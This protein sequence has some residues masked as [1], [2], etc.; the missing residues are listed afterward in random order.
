VRS[1]RARLIISHLVPL[2]ILAV[3]VGVALTYLLQTQVLLAERSNELE[4]QAYLVAEA[5]SLN[6]LIWYDS[7]QA[8]AFTDR[9]GTLLSARLMLLSP[10]GKLLATNYDTFSS[11]IGQILEVPGLTET[12]ESGSALRVNYKQ[13]SSS[14]GAEVLVPVI[15]PSWQVI[16]VIRLIDPLNTVYERFTHTRTLIVGVLAG[17]LILGGAAGALLA[18]DISRPLR[19]ATQGIARMAEGQPLSSLPEQGPREVRSLLRAFNSLTQELHNLEKSRIRLLANLVHEIGRP[20]G[21]L[22]SATQALEAGAD[23]DPVFRKELI[24]GMT[25]E[26][27]RMQSLLDDLTRLY[28]HT[29]G[30]VSLKHEMISIPVWLNQVLS[31]WREAALEKN[32][33]WELNCPPHIP[34][35]RL[36]PDRMAQALGNVVSNAIK[37]TPEKGT[38]SVTAGNDDKQVWIRVSDTGIGIPEEEITQIFEPFYRGATTHRFPQGMGL[39]LSIAQDLVQAHKGHITVES[40][41]G[42][43]SSFTLWLPRS[44]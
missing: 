36:D 24:E 42:E 5:A 32:L 27:Q 34:D 44:I 21:A 8:E 11:Q 31:P 4:L 9:I 26:I 7:Y 28:D 15:T 37:Y 43:G 20:L 13:G 40:K 12:V 3:V 29:Q 6:P 41:P 38:V 18:F 25:G 33:T 39:G 22:L 23:Q 10:D 2:I 14:G 1:L 35:I 16:G 17:G 30:P 19:R